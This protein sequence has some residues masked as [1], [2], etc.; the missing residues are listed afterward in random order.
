MKLHPLF[1]GHRL[2][3]QV[4][5]PPMGVISRHDVRIA[6][7]LA[8]SAMVAVVFPRPLWLWASRHC[9]RLHVA[10]EK[11]NYSAITETLN[12]QG[13]EISHTELALD[14]HSRR[15]LEVIETV[16]EYLG[17]SG[18]KNVIV[19]GVANVTRA[20]ESGRGV[21]LWHSTFC[22]AATFEKRGYRVGGLSVTHLR[23]HSHPFSSTAFGLRFLNPVMTRVE[24]Q[25]LEDL[26]VLAPGGG[27]GALQQLTQALKNNQVIS[28]TAI[29]SGKTPIEVPFLGGWLK[30]ARGVPLLAFSTGAVVIPNMVSIHSGP[31]YVVEF[32]EPLEVDPGLSESEFHQA[33]IEAYAARMEPRVRTQPGSWRGLIL[34]DAWR[35]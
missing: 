33:M 8:L 12:A 14:L 11:T 1:F 7:K 15:Y 29:G 3:A 27:R 17:Y 23:S 20:L 32:E 25:Y 30:L 9:A 21:I 22:G 34:S 35:P 18:E 13:I 26:V 28:V 10:A 5:V 6:L 24:N 19:E 4:N 16:S 31:K 2:G